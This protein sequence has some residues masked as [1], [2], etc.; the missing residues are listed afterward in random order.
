MTWS[1]RGAWTGSAYGEKYPRASLQLNME[2]GQNG[3][4]EPPRLQLSNATFIIKNCRNWPRTEV[5]G[6]PCSAPPP[7]EPLEAC[8]A[9]GWEQPSTQGLRSPLHPR[10]IRHE[11]HL[12]PSG[13]LT[14]TFPAASPP[15]TGPG[16]QL[17]RGPL[18]TSLHGMAFPP[19][20]SQRNDPHS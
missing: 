17:S 14:H 7:P 13:T 18:L 2:W 5:T 4:Q 6:A 10:L 16:L 12:R 3:V 11:S 20:S 8:A 15:P 19:P 9:G 1:M